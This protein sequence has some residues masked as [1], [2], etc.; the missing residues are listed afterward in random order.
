MVC[1]INDSGSHLQTLGRGRNP[2]NSIVL[3]EKQF[4]T[5]VAVR[6]L[7]KERLHFN[8]QQNDLVSLCREQL[9][10]DYSPYRNSVN[11]V[12]LF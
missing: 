4:N 10:Y 5:F 8:T 12:F 2:L 1:K 6:I 11:I 3:N 9:V 7:T